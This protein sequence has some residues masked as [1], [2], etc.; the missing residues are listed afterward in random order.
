MW[1]NFLFMF[2]LDNFKI[3]EVNLCK[4]RKNNYILFAGPSESVEP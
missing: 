3:L 1:F 2:E 4:V